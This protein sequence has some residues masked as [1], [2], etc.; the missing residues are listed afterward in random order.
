MLPTE[1]W[2]LPAVSAYLCSKY[3]Q[4]YAGSLN[5]NCTTN[6]SCGQHS[7]QYFHAKRIIYAW[8]ALAHHIA[9][10][11]EEKR[12]VRKSVKSMSTNLH[13]YNSGQWLFWLNC[14]QVTFTWQSS[15]VPGES[16]EQ[17]SEWNFPTFEFARF[18]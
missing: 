2:H 5:S 14:V 4:K 15:L 18:L 3:L 7:V 16:M 17:R 11:W 6:I 13:L 8:P 12:S 1:A 9:Y 10:C